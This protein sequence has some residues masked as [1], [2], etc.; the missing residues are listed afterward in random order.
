MLDLNST[1]VSI[2]ERSI[3]ELLDLSLRVWRSMFWP[4]LV[5]GLIGMLPCL[6]FNWWWLSGMPHED[7]DDNRH[8]M[9]GLLLLSWWELPLA[10]AP[11][12]ALLGQGMFQRKLD[13]RRAV[14][15]IVHCVL[16]N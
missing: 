15:D 6:L 1:L 4:L 2:R 13:Y 12:T 14:R 16:R 11:I 7:F 8:Y 10:T 3:G 5:A 9:I